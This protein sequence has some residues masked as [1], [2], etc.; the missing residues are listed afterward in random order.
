MPYGFDVPGMV[1][2]VLPTSTVAAVLLPVE[3]TVVA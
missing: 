2:M 1:L 3:V